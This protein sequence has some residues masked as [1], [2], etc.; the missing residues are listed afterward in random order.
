MRVYHTLGPIYSEHS[1]TL[2]LGSM[3]SAISRNEGKYYG[4]KRNRFW[5]VLEKIYDEEIEEWKEFIIKHNLALWDVIS[6]CEIT[7]SSDA[8]IREVKVN[9]IE[10]LIENTKIKNIFL[11]GNK[12]AVLY[13]RYVLPKTKIKG[14]VLPSPSPAN[15]RADFDT[16]CEKYRIIKDVTD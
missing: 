11:L 10:S 14:V 8:S 7:G 2:I 12:A 3:P 1:K 5:P 9:D 4:N 16:L 13:N 6:S 15:A